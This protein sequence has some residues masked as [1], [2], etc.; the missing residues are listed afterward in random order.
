MSRPPHGYEP[1]WRDAERE[2]AGLPRR[3][4]G[5]VT[6]FPKSGRWLARWALGAYLREAHG[7]AEPGRIDQ[8]SRFAPDLYPSDLIDSRK[9]P[10]P[11]GFAYLDRPEVPLVVFSHWP[12]AAELLAGLPK[13][14]VLRDPRAVMVSFY[15][16]VTE[17]ERSWSRSFGDFIRAPEYGVHRFDVYLRS[18]SGVPSLSFATYERWQRDAPREL[19]FLLRALDIDP[20]PAHVERAT[21][22]S[23]FAAMREAEDAAF[24]DRHG[25]ARHV[26]RGTVD[27]WRDEL[28]RGERRDLESE[29]ATGLSD[30]SQ[31]LLAEAGVELGRRRFSVRAFAPGSG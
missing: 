31:R 25:N 29:L 2:A 8:L 24:P 10:G 22:A 28:T 11:S 4:D 6:S 16:W 13:V 27:G 9:E 3:I 19:A 15:R 5:L 21:A 14:M 26:R 7:L 17:R 18:W 23:T 20:L 12:Y 30:A 1:L